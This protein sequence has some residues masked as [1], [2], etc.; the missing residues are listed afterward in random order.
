MSYKYLGTN[1]SRPR[2]S[3][4]RT[5]F[6]DI[7]LLSVFCVSKYW[8]PIALWTHSFRSGQPRRSNRQ[9]TTTKLSK[10]TWSTSECVVDVVVAYVSVFLW[11]RTNAFASAYKWIYDHPEHARSRQRHS[12]REHCARR[13]TTISPSHNPASQPESPH[14]ACLETATAASSTQQQQPAITDSNRG[15]QQG[16][17]LSLWPERA[18][19]SHK[20]QRMYVDFKLYGMCHTTKCAHECAV[21]CPRCVFGKN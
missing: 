1:Q 9:R 17:P 21:I 4:T 10:N 14:G 15:E 11:S 6:N 18:N 7:L 13:T 12:T 8:N 19:I 2:F 3:K 16:I 5:S 20:R